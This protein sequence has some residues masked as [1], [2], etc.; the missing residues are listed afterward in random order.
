MLPTGPAPSRAQRRGA[1]CTGPPSTACPSDRRNASGIA[2][3]DANGSPEA[4]PIHQTHGGDAGDSVGPSLGFYF[5]ARQTYTF[6]R[7]F[8]ISNVIKVKARRFSGRGGGRGV[9][10]CLPNLYTLLW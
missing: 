2:P 7:V 1:T 9:F 3:P 8:F 5:C 4:L 10:L 6:Y